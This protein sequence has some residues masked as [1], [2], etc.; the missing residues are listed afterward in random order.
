MGLSTPVTARTLREAVGDDARAQAEYLKCFRADSA[1]KDLEAMRACLTEGWPVEKRKWS[2]MG[3]SY[4]GFVS[5]CYLS[6]FPE[7]LKEVF[8]MGGLPPV[9]LQIRGQRLDEVY[10]RLVKKMKERNGVYYGKFPEDVEAVR[11]VIGFLQKGGGVELPNGGRLTAERFMGLGIAFGAHGGLDCVH[12]VVLRCVSELEGFGFLTRPTLGRVESLGAFDDAVL[13]GV[14]HEACYSSGVATRWS[15]ERVMGQGEDFDVKKSDGPV[16]FAGEVVLRHNFESYTELKEL[17]P[18]AEVLAQ[19]EDW[20]ELYDVDQLKRN[21]VPV[22]SS[23]YVDDIYVD[24]GFA[25][26]TAGLIKGCKTFVTNAM[27]HNAPSAKGEELMRALF[28]LKEDSLD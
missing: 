4:G 8:T 5:V 1:V 17:A 25:Q 11:R 22:Y 28:A 27:Y 9:G 2:L 6:W 7:G 24:F 26:E 20:P 14:L 13:Y 21:E 19:T 16:L 23:T 3:Q 10:R 18:V 15:A 12:D